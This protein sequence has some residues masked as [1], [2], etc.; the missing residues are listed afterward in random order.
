MIT[1]SISGKSACYMWD[2]T[3]SA[4]GSNEISSCLFHYLTTESFDTSDLVLFSDNCYGQNKNYTVA[5]MF[6]KVLQVNSNLKTITHKFLEVGHTHMECDGVH[7]QIEKKKK[8]YGLPISHPHDWR[9]LVRSCNLDVVNMTRENFF[10]FAAYNKS[11]FLQ[12]F[13]VV[14]DGEAV[15]MNWKNIRTL[16][17]VSGEAGIVHLKEF[18]TDDDFKQADRNK[19]VKRKAPPKQQLQVLNAAALPVP[20]KK[21]KDLLDLLPFIDQQFWPFYQTLNGDSA[22]E[23]T[24][25]DIYES[26]LEGS[27]DLDE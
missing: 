10:D 1:L 13:K 5:A 19:R 3:V 17:V 23:D 21:K 15:S 18:V 22:M 7:G 27:G 26:D 11:N 25:A 14:L 2:E 8:K 6:Q 20:L 12:K 9:Q 16:K 24:H 4:R